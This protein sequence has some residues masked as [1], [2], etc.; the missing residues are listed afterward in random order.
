MEAIPDGKNLIAMADEPKNNSTLN[1]REASMARP[2][3]VTEI[4]RI[5]AAQCKH[6]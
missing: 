4:Q 5:A 3:I 1:T 6:C 2:C